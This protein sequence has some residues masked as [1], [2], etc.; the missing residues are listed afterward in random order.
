MIT[1][2]G[3]DI[4]EQSK[5]MRKAILVALKAAFTGA[6]AFAQQELRLQVLNAGLGTKMANAIRSRIYPAGE[7]SLAYGPAGEVYANGQSAARII[8]AFTEGANIVGKRGQMLAIP[9]PAAPTA[10]YGTAMTPAQVESRYGR[11]LVTVPLKGHKARAMLCLPM[12]TTKAGK[13]NPKG[14]K[15]AAAGAK[16]ADRRNR[17]VP[18]FLLVPSVTL[19]KRLK[20]ADA[21]AAAAESKLPG[22]F[23]AAFGKAI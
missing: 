11:K 7:A 12:P 5:A 4:T 1:A 19:S 22:L 15:L 23:D 3:P 17:L 8:N 18:M 14:L 16:G 20:P 21:I 13:A 10:R 9:L 6:T 2:T